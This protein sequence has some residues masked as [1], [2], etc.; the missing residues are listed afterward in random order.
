M[1]SCPKLYNRL[2]NLIVLLLIGFCQCNTPV[3]IRERNLVGV[4]KTDSITNYVNGF[5]QV[6]NTPDIHWPLYRYDANGQ[7]TESRFTQH[8]TFGYKLVTSDSLIY[9][10]SFGAFMSGFKVLELDDEK[11][12]LKRMHKPFLPGKNQHL[13]EIRFFSKIPAGS[14]SDAL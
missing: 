2:R 1:L 10:D 9:T 14:L 13:Y 6:S 12:V 5:T 3:F 7:L 11:L 8:R 4:W